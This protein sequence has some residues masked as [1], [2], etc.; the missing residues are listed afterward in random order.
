VSIPFQLPFEIFALALEEITHEKGKSLSAKAERA[1]HQL[2]Q[3]IHKG[4]VRRFRDI[5][6]KLAPVNHGVYTQ[7]QSLYK[8]AIVS[9]EHKT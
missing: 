4:G 8:G 5:N 6:S 7:V 3:C 9:A 2:F 1:Y